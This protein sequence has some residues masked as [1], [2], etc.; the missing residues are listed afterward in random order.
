M[1]IRL[2]EFLAPFYPDE[3]E[4]LRV[5][6]FA[7]REYPK[8][9]DKQSPKPFGDIFSTE[10]IVTR[11]ALRDDRKLHER[12]KS[13][14]QLSG[15][16]FIV[17][18]GIGEGKQLPLGVCA[19]KSRKGEKPEWTQ[20][21][22][23]EDITRFN[24]FFV[25]AD[26][27]GIDE[28]LAMLEGCALR[29]CILVTTRKSVHGYWLCAP[30]VTREEWADI[31]LRLITYFGSDESIKNPSRVMRLPNLDH[32]SYDAT[33]QTI[34]RKLVEI[35]RFE[36]ERRFTADEMRGA[37]PAV[38]IKQPSNRHAPPSD[39]G[40]YPDWATLGNELRR[41]MAAH[42]TAHVQGDKV[43]L[44]GVCHDGKGDSA[45]FFN[46]TTGR[47]HCD[48]GCKKEDVLRACG[49]PERPAGKPEWK[50]KGGLTPHAALRINPEKWA[51]SSETDDFFARC[52]AVANNT[53][54]EKRA[55]LP[56]AAVDEWIV[57]AAVERQMGTCGDCGTT[58]ELYGEWCFE[59]SELR[60]FLNDGP[61]ALTCS[62]IG[63]N[64][65]RFRDCGFRWYCG[66]CER[67]RAP[68]DAVWSFQNG[69]KL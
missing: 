68:R 17:N 56:S 25:E 5:R 7:P 18:A 38:E 34:E 31:Q 53:L 36:P 43:V 30:G 60:M 67:D 64:R 27:K 39:P 15:M 8:Y 61:N 55:P 23:D 29:P 33:S 14:N 44:K 45:L 2:F 51:E 69:G 66:N 59:C 6:T 65:W 10:Y 22:K 42:P 63:A 54:I 52:P 57:D 35:T 37:F 21:V 13:E 19:R 26:D 49:L 9:R 3:Q 41:R 62:C 12:I 48:A 40:E 32:L 58:A 4:P 28:Q 16:Y 50:P 47:Y 20:Y 46:I 11:A 1:R 24:A